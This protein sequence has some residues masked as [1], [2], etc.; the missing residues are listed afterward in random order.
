MKLAYGYLDLKP[1]EFWSL[2]L[3]EINNLI[4]GLKEKREYEMMM[5]KWTIWHQEAMARQKRLMSLKRFIAGEGETRT[6][7]GE[8]LEERQNEH[9]ELIKRMGVR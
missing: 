4:I 2:T 5:I 8:E 6:L 3:K 1:H 7:E 9:E